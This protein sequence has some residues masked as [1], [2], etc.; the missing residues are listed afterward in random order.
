MWSQEPPETVSEVVNLKFSWGE[1]GACPQTPLDWACLHTPYTIATA[2]FP[3][4]IILYKTLP[5]N[6]THT[7]TLRLCA[8]RG[9]HPQKFYP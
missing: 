7:D 4:E 8:Y 2:T 3:Q 6:F 5:R 1:R 9:H